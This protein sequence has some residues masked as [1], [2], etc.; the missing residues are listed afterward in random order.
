MAAGLEGDGNASSERAEGERVGRGLEVDDDDDYDGDEIVPSCC[1]VI[2]EQREGQRSG[3]VEHK[4]RTRAEGAE[5]TLCV[6]DFN[7]FSEPAL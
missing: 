5:L 7:T 2:P 3:R 4:A 6:R 1:S